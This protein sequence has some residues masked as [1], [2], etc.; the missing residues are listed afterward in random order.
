[1]ALYRWSTK[2]AGIWAWFNPTNLWTPNQVLKRNSNWYGWDDVNEVPSWWTE[3]QVLTKWESGY[4]WD[5]AWWW[6]DLTLLATLARRWS[7]TLSITWYKAILFVAT[8]RYW[9]W[10]TYYASSATIP[11]DIINTITQWWWTLQVEMKKLY[12]DNTSAYININSSLTFSNNSSSD[13]IYVY[14]IS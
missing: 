9:S 3:G 12:N 5:D 2:L 10:N 13:P 8:Y 14:G 4:W 11:T 6:W 1:M 7:Q